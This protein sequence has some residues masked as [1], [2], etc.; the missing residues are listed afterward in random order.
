VWS[1]ILSF[2]VSI[3]LLLPFPSWQ[4]LVG[5]ITSATVLSFGTGPLALAVMRRKLPNQER[6]FKLPGGD[7]IP[8]LAFYST[9]MIVY[10]AGW[11]TNLD[12]MIAILI[13]YVFLV[14]YQLVSKPS[15]RPALDFKASAYWVLP[16][17]ILMA[18]V[19][20]LFDPASHP[21]MFFWVFLI[22]LAITAVIYYVAIKITLPT[23]KIEQYIEDAA[24]ESEIE[25]ETLAGGRIA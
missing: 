5:F 15:D 4:Q 21:G 19:S 9:N 6:P 3:I 13:G 12:L 25:E 8:F 17:L 11:A 22:N 20:W 16:W 23:A 18:L 1:L 10:F 7:I 2:F 14:I 24:H